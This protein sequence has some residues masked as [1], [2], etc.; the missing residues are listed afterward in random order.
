VH[1]TLWE[2][3]RTGGMRVP[4]RIYA[5]EKLMRAIRGDQALVQ[6]ANVAH[7]P[8]IVGYSI[9]MPDIHWGYG[10][11]IGGVAA[12]DPEEGGVVSPGGV[13]YD[14]NCGVRLVTIDVP[15]CDVQSKIQSVVSRLYQHVPCGVGSEGAIWKLSKREVDDVARKGARWALEKGLGTREDVE[16]TE[17]EGCIRGA[18]PEAVS[19]RAKERGAT[20]V[21]T[22]GSGNHF[23]EVQVVEEVYLPEIADAFGVRE[24]GI[25]LLIHCGSR[26]YGYQVC[27]D[28]IRVM[29]QAMARHKIVVPDRQLCC[30]PVKSDEGR[31]YLAAMACA[32]NYAWA[33]RQVIMRNTEKALLEALGVSPKELNLRLV[34]D[35]CHNIC[36]FETHR[37]NGAM[38]KLCIHRKGATRA[39]PAADAFIPER[40]RAAGQP[41][42]IPGTM[43]TFS[44]LCVGTP[45]AL[46]ET[47]GST[48]HGAGRVMSRGEA[49]RRG[50]G[51]S[52]VDELK[53]K[54][55]TIMAKGFRTIAE[56]MPDAY[57]DVADVVSVMQQAGIT[58]TVARLRPIGVIK[59]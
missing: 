12:T 21:G 6:V 45:R 55:I 25:T 52:I 35:V 1:D 34:Y 57:K 27:D 13:G 28:Y 41:I 49:I 37:V 3:P 30:A 33:N 56:E 43:G 32:A 36:K 42:L 8:G 31:R 4:G 39:A 24:G 54:G 23:L 26:G 16:C 9:A 29:N 7:L 10:F 44:F 46:D 48:C 2:I 53:Q 17:E 19:E 15:A 5:D 14:I 11:P 22:L 20:Q 59:G 47:W 38:K 18:D 50:K 58:Q 40:Y 51:R